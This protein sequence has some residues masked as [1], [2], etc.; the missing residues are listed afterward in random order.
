MKTLNKSKRAEI[1]TSIIMLGIGIYM[2]IE[3]MGFRGNDKYFPMII[4]G[5]IIAVSIWVG[6]EDFLNKECCYDLSKINFAGIFVALVALTLYILLF[7]KIGY[8]LSTFLL[9][10]G[11]I[12]GLRYKSIKGAIL[13]P[14]IMVAVIFVIFRVLLKVP[15]PTV[16]F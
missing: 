6:V 7:R 10:V 2:V 14:A 16:I 15:L 4:G 1:L 13:W 5:C 3:S 12:L 8:I 11:I 9:G